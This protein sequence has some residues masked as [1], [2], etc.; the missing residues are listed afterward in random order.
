M[1]GK[2]IKSKFRKYSGKKVKFIMYH[3]ELEGIVCG[4]DGTD[5]IIAITK[6]EE[7]FSILWYYPDRNTEKDKILTHKNNPM[8][9]SYCLPHKLKII[10]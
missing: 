7:N 5:L 6:N 8:G 10:D 1:A 3:K 4:H 9:Y 2:S